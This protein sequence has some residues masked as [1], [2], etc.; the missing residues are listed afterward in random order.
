M[1]RPILAND[2][3]RVTNAQAVADLARLG[4]LRR[5][6]VTLDLTVGPNAGFWTKWRPDSLSTNDI[7]LDVKADLHVDVRDMRVDD[8][9]G[10]WKPGYWDVVAWDPPYGYRGTSRL[11][12]DATYGLARDYQTPD[13]IDALLIDG[14]RIACDL[15]R[16]VALVKCQDQNIASH[17]RDQSGFVTEAARAHGATVIQKLYIAVRREQPAG[18]KQRNVWGYHSVLL[19]LG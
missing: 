18:K 4:I 12:S 8:G 1:T 16:R 3:A 15:A 7:D 13:Q 6:D 5:E 19:V 11:A 2:P 10:H 17:F 14:M 9:L